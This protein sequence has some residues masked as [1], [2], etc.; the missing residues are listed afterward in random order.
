MNDGTQPT[1]GNHLARQQQGIQTFLDGVAE[2]KH[3]TDRVVAKD[4]VAT[5]ATMAGTYAHAQHCART[6][7]DPTVRH[8][9]VP[10]RARRHRRHY[11]HQCG[12]AARACVVGVDTLLTAADVSNIIHRAGNPDD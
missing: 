3:E 4:P 9:C 7:G 10:W 2:H 8:V 6:G 1:A 12:R 5:S 11:R